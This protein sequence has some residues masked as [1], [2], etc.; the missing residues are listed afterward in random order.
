MHSNSDTSQAEYVL[1][2][3]EVII[4]HTD[5]DSRITYANP[6][7][8]SSSQY[9]L[10][11]CLGQPQ[12][13]VRHPDMPREAF[14]DLWRTIRAGKS[15]TGIVKNRRKHGGFYW[16]RANVTP[17][18][19]DG[20][21]TGYMSVRVKPTRDEIATAEK[22][23]A[24]I[25]SGSAGSLCIKEGR[26]VDESWRGACRQLLSPSLRTSAW[27]VLGALIL[28]QGGVGARTVLLEGWGLSGL[29]S[30]LGMLIA[31][32]ALIYMQVSVVGALLALQ[33]TASRLIAGDTRSRIEELGPICI[34]R[35]AQAFEQLRVK[36]DGVLKDN[37]TAATELGGGV[38]TVTSSIGELSDRA[39]ENAASLEE[40]AASVEQLSATVARNAENTQQAAQLAQECSSKTG[41]G[42]QVVTQ[43][44]ETMTA[45][46][47]SSRRI[48][49]IVGIIDGIAFQTNL[50]AL[51]AAV[52]AA[53]A[54]EQ[55]R[56][57]AVVAQEVRS[58]A[59]RSASASKEIRDLINTSSQTVAHGGELAGQADEA[60]QQVVTAVKRVAEVIE[61][62]DVA[63]Q[64]Q[65]AGIEQ[66]NSAVRQMDEVTQRDA[67]MMQE[68]A[69]TAAGLKEQSQIMLGAISAFTLHRSSDAASV[70][71][72]SMVDGTAAPF[73]VERRRAA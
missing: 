40:T 1:P 50:L 61:E 68:L 48:G 12:N 37:L 19:H 33:A 25:R 4:T 26:V 7:F 41:R 60:M 6:A 71:R 13:L 18:M 14:A 5:P 35:I 16:V 65:S 3:G 58:L 29:L 2:E 17:M 8:L 66:I 46:A 31:A 49:E 56:G 15:W 67:Q 44:H 38:G 63:G 24:R 43:M 54:G 47:Q 39:T 69:E 57:F 9:S 21:I 73:R 72:P 59:Q 10:E 55:G 62:I 27:V 36:L 20:R 22:I 28:L 53:R 11:E 51:N 32:G 45:I 42:R 23:Y 64:E 52:E 34:A 30:G 70:Q